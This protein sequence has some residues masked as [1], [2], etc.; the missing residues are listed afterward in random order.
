MKYLVLLLLLVTFDTWAQITYDEHLGQIAV[1]A[2]GLDHSSVNERIPEKILSR[3]NVMI[4]I[5]N[6]N[7][8]RYEFDVNVDEEV[9]ESINI[10]EKYFNPFISVLEGNS[11]STQAS[12]GAFADIIKWRMS[13][14]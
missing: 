13:M 9:F 5:M 14:L 1:N 8:F 7:L 2:L 12:E 6:P 11:F 3:V 4:F 10:L